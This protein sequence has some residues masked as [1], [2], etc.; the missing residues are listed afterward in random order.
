MACDGFN[1]RYYVKTLVSLPQWQI[2]AGTVGV[3][4]EINREMHQMDVF[5][6]GLG[7]I[8][9][10]PAHNFGLAEPPRPTTSEVR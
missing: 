8:K 5:F 4:W 2:E 7:V 6:E 1:H 10:L 3:V 9:G